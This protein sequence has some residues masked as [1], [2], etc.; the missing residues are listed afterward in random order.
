MGKNTLRPTGSEP[1]MLSPIV[2]T[3][4]SLH[5]CFFFVLYDTLEKGKNIASLPPLSTVKVT[6]SVLSM[7]VGLW[8]LHWQFVSDH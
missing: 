4:I 6:E 1:Y 3:K 2:D 7:S 5:L 8:E